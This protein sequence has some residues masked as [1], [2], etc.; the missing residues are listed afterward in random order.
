MGRADNF[1]TFM[2]RLSA[3][4]GASTYWGPK[5]L[6]R[7]EMGYPSVRACVRACIVSGSVPLQFAVRLVSVFIFAPVHTH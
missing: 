1:T 6:S 4:L 5:G 3:N 7:P 2:C